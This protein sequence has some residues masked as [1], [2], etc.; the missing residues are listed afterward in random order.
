MSLITG[1]SEIPT[2]RP[3]A[4]NKSQHDFSSDARV[5]LPIYLVVQRR[6]YQIA[7]IDIRQ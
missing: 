6:G 1:T 3:M 7:D 5:L 2:R 4:Y